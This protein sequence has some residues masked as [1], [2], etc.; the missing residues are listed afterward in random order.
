M[1]F[2]AGLSLSPQL[3]DTADRAYTLPEAALSA[4]SEMPRVP[5]GG[6]TTTAGPRAVTP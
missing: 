5:G 6:P 4:V 1:A 2:Q 3:E